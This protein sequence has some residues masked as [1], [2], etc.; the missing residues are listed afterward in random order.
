MKTRIADPYPAALLS[1]AMMGVMLGGKS[2]RIDDELSGI[3]L[4][5]EYNL[6]QQKKSRLPARLRD[7]IKRIVEKQ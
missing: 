2:H 6:I 7:R 4:I 1:M 5:A 3:D